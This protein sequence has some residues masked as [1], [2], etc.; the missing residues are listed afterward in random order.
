MK[1]VWSVFSLALLLYFYMKGVAEFFGGSLIEYVGLSGI[2]DLRNK[3]YSQL[4]Q[5]PVGFFH[6]NPVG[7]VM[8]AV[9][10]D[11]EQIRSVFSDYLVDFFRQIFTL[12]RFR[13]VLLVIDWRMAVGSVVLVP[14]VLY[15]GREIGTKNSPIHGK[16]PRAAGGPKP[17]PS[18]NDQRQP[19]GES[20]WNGRFRNRQI[21]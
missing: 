14:L 16:Q 10:S 20:V 4:V 5:Q 15:P 21:P 3:V 1:H 2:T 12:D 7:R 6:G 13:R 17:D 18:G 9:I 8:S 19:R 11:I